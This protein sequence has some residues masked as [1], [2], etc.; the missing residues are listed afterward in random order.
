MNWNAPR[1]SWPEEANWM[2]WDRHCYD[3]DRVL[4][5]EDQLIAEQL[6]RRSVIP[7]EDQSCRVVSG[8]AVNTARK[9]EQYFEFV[10]N[11]LGVDATFR[12]CWSMGCRALPLA[13]WQAENRFATA[14]Q[15]SWRTYLS[16]KQRQRWL[17][18]W[19]DPRYHEAHRWLKWTCFAKCCMIL[20]AC[21]LYV[22]S[23]WIGKL[24]ITLERHTQDPGKSARRLPKPVL[25]SCEESEMSLERGILCHCSVDASPDACSTGEK[26]CV[27][28]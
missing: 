3:V 4:K 12:L 15:T 25:L 14:R 8:A 9:L 19:H 1:F 13:F 7:M 18:W 23:N 21:W 20:N 24:G 10:L 2:P 5:V 6:R 27:F 28:I 16:T 22:L 26:N 17:L 11:G